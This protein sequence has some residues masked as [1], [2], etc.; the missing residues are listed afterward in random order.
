MKYS[1]LIAS[2]IGLAGCESTSNF[3]DAMAIKHMNSQHAPTPLQSAEPINYQEQIRIVVK[4][5][6]MDFSGKQSS[7]WPETFYIAEGE[8]K[9]VKLYQQRN[10]QKLNNHF[11]EVAVSYQ[12]GQVVFDA[13]E[14]NLSV[15]N[16]GIR[17]PLDYSKRIKKC[18]ISLTDNFSRSKAKDIC[19][20]INTN[21]GTDR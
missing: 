16:W 17:L 3:I 19:I 14:A 2:V 15:Q 9:F 18:G 20:E 1:L 10:I 12:P 7:Y 11:I 6:S 8:T 5:G 21:Y 13:N 4:H